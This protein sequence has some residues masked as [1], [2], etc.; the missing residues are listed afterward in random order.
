MTRRTLV[1]LAVW[2]AAAACAG[3]ALVLL[4]P[5]GPMKWALWL[6]FGSAAYFLVSSVVELIVHTYFAS[7]GIKQATR[8]VEKRAEGRLFSGPRM[9]WYLFAFAVL[10]GIAVAVVAP[11]YGDVS[12]FIEHDR[13]LDAGGRWNA[14]QHA[15][16][17][18]A[19]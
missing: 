7:P 13:C 3:V 16:E 6:V 10:F 15:C 8:Y 18:A 5:T 14:V 2:M 9:L 19:Q 12:E 1:F 11:I 17:G 4:Q